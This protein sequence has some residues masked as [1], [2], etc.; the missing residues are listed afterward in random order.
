VALRLRKAQPAMS[1]VWNLVGKFLQLVDQERDKAGSVTE[2]KTSCIE[3]AEKILQT[4]REASEDA[5]RITAHLLPQTGLVLTH[6]YS[7]AV[8]RSLELGVKSGKRLEVYATESYPGMEGKELAKEL[9]AVG[10]PV[11]LIPDSS[12]DSIISKVDLV[13]VGADSVLRDGTLVHKIG[14]NSI[15]VAARK[16]RIP[17]HS[18]CETTKFNVREFL[19]ETPDFAKNLFDTTPG[20]YVSGFTTEIG[21]VE[22]ARVGEQI[23]EMVGQIYP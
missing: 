18:A 9:V 10:V 16:S 21:L 19:G 13:L 5:S 15:A 4:A 20:E 12:V 3:I 1:I 6:S 23:R 8:L 7:N 14:T 17:F 2:L 11:K 22:P